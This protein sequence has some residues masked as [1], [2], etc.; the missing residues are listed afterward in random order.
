MCPDYPVLSYTVV[1]EDDGGSPIE[2]VTDSST[3]IS[4]SGLTED[5]S[6]SY[7][8]IGSNQFGNSR[9]SAPVQFCKLL[10]N[11]CFIFI[12]LNLPSHH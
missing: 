8:I 10:T 12:R 6:Y 9:E 2:Q 1:M 11:A 5:L 4:I 3:T 7:H